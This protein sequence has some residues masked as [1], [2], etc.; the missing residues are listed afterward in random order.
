MKGVGLAIVVALF[1]SGQ[2]SAQQV[3]L[4]KPRPNDSAA[5]AASAPSRV[6]HVEQLPT[7][8]PSAAA[9]PEPSPAAYNVEDSRAVIDWLVNRSSV[10]GR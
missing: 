9:V 8:A 2:S 5:A 7:R 1:L 10:R 6:E 3:E 4:A